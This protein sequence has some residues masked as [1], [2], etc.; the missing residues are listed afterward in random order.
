MAAPALPASF[1]AS[2]LVVG[3]GRHPRHRRSHG[4]RRQGPRV[5]G[6]P[7]SGREVGVPEG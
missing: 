7:L 6:Q 4:G 1:D 3:G 2:G 5:P